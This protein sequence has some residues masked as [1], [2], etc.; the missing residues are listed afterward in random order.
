MFFQYVIYL[1]SAY[2]I[3]LWTSFI[4]MHLLVGSFITMAQMMPELIKAHE[5][6][7]GPMN[8][9]HYISYTQ[10]Y[11]NIILVLHCYTIIILALYLLFIALPSYCFYRLLGKKYVNDIVL[12]SCK[13]TYCDTIGIV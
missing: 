4:G 6:Y 3:F 7:R 13:K 2:F 11:T 5:K 10:R 12:S 1:F 8:F 9:Y